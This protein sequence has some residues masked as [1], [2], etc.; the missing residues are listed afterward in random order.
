MGCPA[1]FS[2]SSFSASEEFDCVRKQPFS[3]NLE[4][5]YEKIALSKV[6]YGRDVHPEKRTG[7]VVAGNPSNLSFFGSC[8]L[9][10][11]SDKSEN[12]SDGWW[13]PRVLQ[14]IRKFHFR[15]LREILLFKTP[16]FVWKV[17]LTAELRCPKELRAISKHLLLQNCLA[18][19]S[20]RSLV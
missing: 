9:V 3:D 8:I 20:W 7:S 15:I 19:L 12:F 14:H 13:V 10:L 1:T 4:M 5:D 17:H 2:T 16:K 18:N 6:L 11:F